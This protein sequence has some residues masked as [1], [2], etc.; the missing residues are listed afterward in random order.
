MSGIR[1]VKQ[2][3]RKFDGDKTVYVRHKGGNEFRAGINAVTS[4]FGK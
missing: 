4:F 2:I 1:I 3:L